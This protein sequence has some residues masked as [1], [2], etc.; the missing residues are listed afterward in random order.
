MVLDLETSGRTTYKRFCNPLDSR[1]R[2]TAVA[3]KIQDDGAVVEYNPV[4]KT[5]S[6]SFQR[7]FVD[8]ETIGCVVGQNLKF[9]LL[10]FWEQFISTYLHTGQH[11][12]D[13][14]T[15]E[16]LLTGQRDT[17]RDLNT[18]ALKYGGN[19]KDDR[20]GIMFKS[21]L[22]AYE[23]PPDL[24]LPYAEEDVVNTEIVLQG[25]LKVARKLS[26]IPLIKTYM[27]HYAA[28]IEMEHNGL[29]IDREK[30]LQL[31]SIYETKVAE[32]TAQAQQLAG[33]ENFNPNSNQQLS[34]ILF[35]KVTSVDVKVLENL[36]EH[37]EKKDLIK[38]I[39]DLRTAAKILKTYIYT[40]DFYLRDNKKKGIKKGDMKSTTGLLPLIM[41]D[42]CVHS[43]FKTSYTHTG[44]LA[45]SNPNVQNLPPEILEVFT[46]RHDDGVIVECDYSQLEV[47]VQAFLTQ[48]TK[49][50]SDIKNGIDFH[51]KR[52]SYAEQ[53]PYDT[54]VANVATSEEWKLKRKAAKQVSFQKA[55]G[56]HPKKIA[57]S[58]GLPLE[59]VERIFHEEDMD[60]PEIKI[61][62]ERVLEEVTRTRTPL[63][64]L[65][66]IRNKDTGAYLTKAG[67]NAA[68]GTFTNINGKIYTFYEKAVLTKRGV[69][70][71]FSLPDIQN[72]PIQGLA[73]DIVA[74][75][76][77]ELFRFAIQHRDKFRLINEVHDSILLDV[78]KEHLDF[79][80]D[81]VRAILENIE[82]N[83]LKHFKI[84]FNVPIKV[85]IHFGQTWR[86]CK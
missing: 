36:F 75:Q 41:P 38:T 66:K 25:Q 73:A 9:D 80:L 3:S 79:T 72:Y 10:W 56:A 47:V 13:T 22:L 15:V 69:Y 31:K 53:L 21:G 23:I 29:Y 65:I 37:S 51:C 78:K 49:M 58:T 1:H 84:H 20:V 60:Y 43:E 77:G 39:L 55:Y 42:G 46:S 48:S 74:M 50:I 7:L 35:N 81:K 16:Y 32:L 70:R 11:I 54:V 82:G 71:Y 5:T 62:Y 14:L 27:L 19:I 86:D 30:L 24:L 4:S 76:V 33:D 26:M 2:I 18:L 68:Y 52:L 61:F 8:P 40:E 45:S 6:I 28:V 57:L 12:W 85:D 67:E 44:R 83:F 63:P 59:M 64:E 17:P 34:Q